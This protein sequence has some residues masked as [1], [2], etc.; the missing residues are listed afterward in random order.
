M[1]INLTMN[2]MKTIMM[3]L[4]V[5]FATTTAFGK[6]PKSEFYTKNPTE[7]MGVWEGRVKSQPGIVPVMA[8][9]A[10]NEV[11]IYIL[12]KI[13]K[14]TAVEK[15]KKTGKF[16]FTMVDSTGSKTKMILSKKSAEIDEI[17]YNVEVIIEKYSILFDTRKELKTN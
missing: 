5:I 6:K 16:I 13:Y 1:K 3:I 8:I 12:N 7:L 10:K 9:N 14:T 4:V 17:Y 11:R 15:E 2:S